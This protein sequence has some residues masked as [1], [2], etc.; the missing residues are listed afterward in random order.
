M[1]W[2]IQEDLYNDNRR[3]DLVAA[4]DRLGIERRFVRLSESKELPD[5]PEHSG[6][7]VVNGSVMLSRLAAEKGWRPGSFLNAN[8]DAQVWSSRYGASCL[9]FGALQSP[10]AE[11]SMPWERAFVRPALDDKSFSGKVME[12][13]EFEALKAASLA[14]DPKVPK[15]QVRVLMAR[16]KRIGQEHRHYVVDGEPVSSSRYKLG[17][18]PN[19][20]EGA[21]EA[22]LDFVRKKAAEWAPARAF[23]MDT[24]ISG[25][26]VGVVEVGCICHAGLYAA[27]V[28]K[29]VAALDSMDFE[30]EPSVRAAVA[31]PL[32]PR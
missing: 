6:G 11:A 27:D 26:E 19:F 1:L 24:Y 9:N 25:D 12:R 10:L 22:V 31:R 13:S 16:P 21:D 7:I 4:L 17:P 20:S 29:I 23:V 32:G 14:G 18:T 30:A 2:V 5:F 3:G 8:F 15:P 28:M